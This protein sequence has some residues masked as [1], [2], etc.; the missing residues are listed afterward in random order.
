MV[1]PGLF[2]RVL[3]TMRNFLPLR[4]GPLLFA[5]G[6]NAITPLTCSGVDLTGFAFYVWSVVRGRLRGK[7]SMN[8][9]G[10]GRLC[11]MH[12]GWRLVLGG[13]VTSHWRIHCWRGKGDD[14]FVNQF[15]QETPTGLWAWVCE[16]GLRNGDSILNAY[17]TR[18]DFFFQKIKKYCQG[19]RV[20]SIFII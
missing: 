2:E 1:S 5:I 3:L 8:G 18:S 4:P 15:K 10:S 19:F 14:V 7:L 11:Q 20:N 17:K 9:M 12:R 6:T 13:R 16:Q